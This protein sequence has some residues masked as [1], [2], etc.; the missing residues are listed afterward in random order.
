MFLVLECTYVEVVGL[1]IF[2]RAIQ[3]IKLLG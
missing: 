3:A 2:S 1:N